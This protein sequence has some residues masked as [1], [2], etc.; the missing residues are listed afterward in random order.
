MFPEPKALLTATPKLPGT[1]GRKMSKS[2]GNTIAIGDPPDVVRASIMTMITDPARERRSD[3]GNPEICP[4]FDYHKVFSD[5]KT[6]ADVDQGCRTAGIGC[7]ECK[8]WLFE[9]HQ[10]KFGPIYERR[11][12]LEKNKK[13][14]LDILRDGTDRARKVA[15]ETMAEVRNAMKL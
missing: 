8:G 3:A 15:G 4:V 12:R 7:V 9:G 5:E 10:N 14:V 13:E 11:V 2:Y 1:D 6:V